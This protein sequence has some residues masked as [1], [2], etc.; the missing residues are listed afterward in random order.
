[1]IDE[2]DLDAVTVPATALE[3]PERWKHFDSGRPVPDIVN[4]LERSR[5][6]H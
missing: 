5:R 6:A 2:A 1:M 4:A 3:L